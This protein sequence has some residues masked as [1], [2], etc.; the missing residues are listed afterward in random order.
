MIRFMTRINISIR[1]LFFILCLPY[2]DRSCFSVDPW[3][4]ITSPD[5]TLEFAFPEFASDGPIKINVP[6]TLYP[7]DAE[8]LFKKEK[9]ILHFLMWFVF[10][11]TTAF[12]PVLFV[13]SCSL[14]P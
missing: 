1:N 2:D 11:C 8:L 10:F 9:D 5:V 3:G 6:L 4:P 13:I 14:N 12:L 7:L